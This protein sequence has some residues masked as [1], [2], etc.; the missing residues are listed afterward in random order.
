[1]TSRIRLADE[2][3]GICE[4]DGCGGMTTS[5]VYSRSRG[6]VILC[7]DAHAYEVADEGHPEYHQTC[8]NCGCEIPVN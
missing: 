6:S 3:G 4:V 1:M 5:I 8:P 7:C 2:L